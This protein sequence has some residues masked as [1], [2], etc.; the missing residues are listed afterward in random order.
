MPR[1]DTHGRP[2]Q[3]PR[4]GADR[5]LHAQFVLRMLALIHQSAHVRVPVAIRG[6][7]V[8]HPD[9]LRGTMRQHVMHSPARACCTT[10][11]RNTATCMN[12]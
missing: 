11:T 3:Q 1:G 4:F 2:L 10:S 6:M 7:I 8:H 12:E 5:L 9:S